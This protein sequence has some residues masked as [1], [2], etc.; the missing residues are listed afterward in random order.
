MALRILHVYFFVLS[1][2]THYCVFFIVNIQ[3]Q[4]SNNGLKAVTASAKTTCLLVGNVDALSQAHDGTIP[5]LLQDAKTKDT[6]MSADQ[7]YKIIR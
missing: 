2:A 6:V 3:C 4:Q 1:V 5:E 7:V